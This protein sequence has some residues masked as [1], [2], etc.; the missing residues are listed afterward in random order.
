MCVTYI[1][2]GQNHLRTFYKSLFPR[3]RIQVGKS[4][5][6]Y[7]EDEEGFRPGVCQVYSGRPSPEGQAGGGKAPNGQCYL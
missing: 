5:V 4:K 3:R 2:N 7:T 1:S 6:N